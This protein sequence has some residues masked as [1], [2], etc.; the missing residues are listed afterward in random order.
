[1]DFLGNEDS[2][3]DIFRDQ[4]FLSAPI[5]RDPLIGQKVI[6]I[7][8]EESKKRTF[9]ATP[10]IV[11]VI[12]EFPNFFGAIKDK[13][14]NKEKEKK[15]AYKDKIEEF[16]SGC[17]HFNISMVMASQTLTKRKM[18]IETNNFQA[19]IA[20]HFPSIQFSQNIIGSRKAYDLHGVGQMLF[21]SKETG[22]KPLFGS[23]MPKKD[24]PAFLEEIK[25]ALSQNAN[26]PLLLMKQT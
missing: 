6:D 21:I 14:K 24:M 7:L 22:E 1:M 12:D 26:I 16:L 17:R 23:F 15:L 25:K 18:V 3:Y 9:H 11:C 8:Y 2:D 5:I 13:D 20:F 4:P 19:R 10:R